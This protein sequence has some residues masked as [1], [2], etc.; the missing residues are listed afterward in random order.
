MRNEKNLAAACTLLSKNTSLLLLFIHSITHSYNCRNITYMTAPEAKPL[1]DSPNDGVTAIAYLPNA[2][3][4][5]LASTSWEGSLRVYDTKEASLQLNQA[6][7][8]GPLL[9]LAT[10]GKAVVTGG[11]DG[12][13]RR[14]ELSSSASELIGRHAPDMSESSQ[15][16]CSCLTSLPSMN[17]V[18]SAGWNKKVS[19]WDLRTQGSVAVRV[20]G[21]VRD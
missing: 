15:M 12:S 13:I 19:I 6:M 5:L 4:S 9:C 10:T 17:V 14:M 20:I 8:S 11:L 16:A 3:M 1:P 18:A 7:E 2:S 21:V